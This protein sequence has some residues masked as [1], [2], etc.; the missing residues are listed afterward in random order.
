M[1]RVTAT[2]RLQRILAILPW[3][4]QHQGASIDEVVARFGLTH[5]QLVTDLD[6]VFYNV[7][8][9]PFTPDML[10]DVRIEEGHI[11]VQLGDYFRRPLRL[12]HAEALTLLAAGRALTDRPGTDP[13]GPLARAVAKLAAALGDGADRAV[14]V[15]LGAAD[16]EVLAAVQEAVADRRRVAID[17]YSYGRG[18]ASSRSI[19]S[20]RVLSNEGHWYVIGW[21]HTA[22]GERLFRIDRIRSVEPTGE[23]FEPPEG[24]G[25]GSLDLSDS[26]RT[27]ELVGPPSIAWVASTY[28][29]D[30]S[31]ELGDGRL[32][33][34]LPVTATP[35][36]ERLLLRL[37]PGTVATDL[38]TGER[39]DDVAR[40]AAT[41][42]LA[43]YGPI[44]PAA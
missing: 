23:H 20:Y 5:D 42:L 14:E 33:I 36:L 25:D 40:R 7:G 19:D 1:A 41:R 21:C 29:Y 38:G 9:H 13:D 15:A 2:E 31:E 27:V 28:P 16:P 17:Y 6:F 24:A 11:Y 35:W 3:I 26:P 44:D 30:E 4:V 10:A 37:D 43:R 39:L 8:L 32:R 12:T 34:V 18:G 22:N